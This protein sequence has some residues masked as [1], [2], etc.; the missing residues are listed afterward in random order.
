[1]LIYYFR[2]GYFVILFI[3]GSVKTLDASWVPYKPRLLSD[4]F[5][6]SNLCCQI[7]QL[8]YIPC[9]DKNG[10]SFFVFH[11]DFLLF[12]RGE[13]KV[14]M[15]SYLK[16]SFPWLPHSGVF[17]LSLLILWLALQLFSRIIFPYLTSNCWS[18]SRFLSEPFFSPH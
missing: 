12:F 1:M 6:N 9:F 18:Y 3:T 8:E 13:G 15:S 16:F 4:V 5:C 10:D 14:L 11:F 2:P 17:L 7:C